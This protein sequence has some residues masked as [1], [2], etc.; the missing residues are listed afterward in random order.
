[1][2][3]PSRPTLD[4]DAVRFLAT[5]M[6]ERID[7]TLLRIKRLEPDA[8]AMI[9]AMQPDDQLWEWSYSN[10]GERRQPNYSMGWCVV[11]DGLPVDSHCHSFG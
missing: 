6:T 10:P 3:A 7:P 5:C 8:R 9:L 1:M 11:R 4:D 2:T